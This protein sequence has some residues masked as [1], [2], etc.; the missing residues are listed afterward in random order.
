M[1]LKWKDVSEAELFR[2]GVYQVQDT[3][4]NDDTPPD[5][6]R[7][8]RTLP[9]NLEIKVRSDGV[10]P[11]SV[12]AADFVPKGT[13]F[14]PVVGVNLSP[15]EAARL[16]EKTYFYRVYDLE[17][18]EVLFV[19]DGKDT[20]KSNWMRYVPPAFN[21]SMQNLV[22]YQHESNIYFLTIKHIRPGEEL[23]V[24]YCPSYAKRMNYP[25]SGELMMANL[26]MLSRQEVELE[27][28]KAEAIR[29][30]TEIYN[31]QKE[32]N[33][34]KAEF[35]Q[36]CHN[37]QPQQAPP[38]PLT[39]VIN[40]IIKEELADSSPERNSLYDYSD[41]NQAEE[42]SSNSSISSKHRR[43]SLDR[44]ESP[45]SDSG[46]F[47][48]P[49]RNGYGSGQRSSPNNSGDNSPTAGNS[50][51]LDLTSHNNN[52]N[53]LRI[54]QD[55]GRKRSNSSDMDDDCDNNSYR[56]HKMKMYKASYNGHHPA[57]NSASQSNGNGSAISD[58]CSGSSS[59]SRSVSTPSPTEKQLQQPPAAH[60]AQYLNYHP[61]AS[62]TSGYHPQH[63]Q[64][65]A[66]IVAR[67]E[68]IDQRVVPKTETLPANFAIMQNNNQ[69]EKAPMLSR[70]FPN[71][72]PP[73]QAS[74]IMV[75][76]EQQ[77]F[78]EDYDRPV[79]DARGYK[80]LPYP[81]N[82]KDGKIE[83]KCETC[84]KVFG[85]LSN[86]KVHLRTHSGERPF[87]CQMC[88]KNFTQLAHLQKHNLVH[89]GG[90]LFLK[91]FLVHLLARFLYTLENSVF[92]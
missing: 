44:K 7:A 29:Q 74:S 16:P 56:K 23:T 8:Q 52:N 55:N 85:Q 6:E 10:H 86:L 22:A 70:L 31:K 25:P 33:T 83:Y 71:P 36:R 76:Q 49:G 57:N 64:T 30:V 9:P 14:G 89:T 69:M 50:H 21:A 58:S 61:G 79:K 42:R 48:S 82:K 35:S 45:V 90:F 34:L 1:E 4:V 60:Q 68:S 19:I 26:E 17:I 62:S 77:Q 5:E 3:P 66:F 47:G 39:S 87:Q 73:P 80:A 41:D 38:Q 81:L 43:S 11:H 24:W 18:N 15:D 72:P 78:E 67:R 91:Y 40:A 2:L 37:H 13:R 54:Q 92:L 28:Q 51:V 46:Y 84:E 53:L 88:P 59:P 20:S 32:I 12:V 63:Q 27:E 65:P 75:K